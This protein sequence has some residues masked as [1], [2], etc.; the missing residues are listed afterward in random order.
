MDDLFVIDTQGSEEI[1]CTT[2]TVAREFKASST[3]SVSQRESLTTSQAELQVIR[4]IE[5]DIPGTSVAAAST[6]ASAAAATTTRNGR[7]GK[8]PT[9]G[10]DSQFGRLEVGNTQGSRASGKRNKNK[11]SK[12]NNKAATRNNNVSGEPSKPQVNRKRPPPKQNNGDSEFDELVEDFIANLGENGIDDLLAVATQSKFFSREIG[13]GLDYHYKT[14][15]DEPRDSDADST[16]DGLFEVD[17]PMEHDI[18][19]V[20]EVFEG[21][22]EGL[23]TGAAAFYSNGGYDEDDGFPCS[24]NLEGL[25]GP[26]THP[27]GKKK[28]HRH[29]DKAQNAKSF[30]EKDRAKS[31]HD[32]VKNKKNERETATPGFDPYTVL[33]RLDMLA[34]AGDLESI[35]L[36]PMNRYERQIVHVLSREYK[37]KSKSHGTGNR[38][39]PVLTATPSTCM[40]KNRRRIDKIL[41]LFDNGGL[42]PEHLIGGG[43]Y[44]ENSEG[45]SKGKKI[46]SRPRRGESSNKSSDNAHGKMVAENAPEV[47]A[48]NIGHK[49]LQQMGWQPGKGLGANEEGRATPVDVVIRGGRRGLGA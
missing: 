6:A 28:H 26:E 22:D 15:L 37:V 25:P 3:P 4:I 7:K 27:F 21:S 1:Q 44:L 10:L 45:K 33:K 38:R 8:Q 31:K 13:G 48:T 35:W 5:D 34:R 42:I 49:M 23:D 47:S 46:N 14:L 12:G 9:S 30:K 39:A 17:N 20:D 32:R 40:P 11:P 41:L 24:M 18:D 29:L 2:T 43:G 19:L 36:Q 16:D